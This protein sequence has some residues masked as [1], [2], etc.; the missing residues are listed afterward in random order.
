MERGLSAIIEKECNFFKEQERLKSELISRFDFCIEGLYND[1]DDW[2]YKYI[3]VKNLKRFLM[4]T[5]VYPNEALLKAII[6]RLDTDGDARLSYQEFVQSIELVKDPT[7][8][9][10]FN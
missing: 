8:P 7:I 9:T 10:L 2:S 1:V 6:R 5:N 3:D 4:K